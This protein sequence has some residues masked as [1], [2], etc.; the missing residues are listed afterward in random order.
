MSNLPRSTQFRDNINTMSPGPLK[1]G[2]AE[3]Y[4]YTLG[5]C[6]DLLLEK[7]NQARKIN[8][9][10]LGDPSQLPYLAA[11]SVLVQG[12]NE[13]N[14]SF[15]DRVS[16]TFPNAR[17][18]GSRQ[19]I[20]RELQAYATNMQPGVAA[21]LPE[22]AIVGG[23]P[24]SATWDLLYNG[25]K[26]GS[27]PVHV[28]SANGWDWDG[29]IK[30]WRS[31]LVLYM[32]LVARGV[33]GT[34]ATIANGP[35]TTIATGQ[36]VSGVWVPG[37]TSLGTYYPFA[38]VSGLSGMTA[39]NLGDWLVLSSA[40]HGANDGTFQIVQVISATTVLIA[41]SSFVATDTAAWSLSHYPWIAPGLC[42]GAPNQTFGQGAN[43]LPPADLGENINGVW[44]PSADT[45]DYG[46]ASSWGLSC[47][48]QMIQSMRQLVQ[49]W[50]QAGAYYPNI[51]VAF[52][53]GDGTYGNA[54]SPY[55]TAGR[56][57]PNGS[58]G[59]IGENLNG[60]WSPT[61]NTNVSEF[62]AYDC[63]CGGSGDYAHCTVE[64]VT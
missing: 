36:N 15:V 17:N 37:G 13:P 60:V 8:M 26:Q 56:G 29:V 31:W 19:S 59:T 16:L 34:G 42:W 1:T 11:D 48:A 4:M 14:A 3:R 63:F 47:T 28:V 39:E 40:T 52:D 57:L 45:G 18:W 20:L 33:S 27:A 41:N 58:F 25:A 22:M 23:G 43:P 64:N 46:F 44:Q 61:R 6:S 35:A 32:A 24:S 9:P 10:G 50:K 38:Q 7:A 12:P 30:P 49:R 21:V 55:S 51:I 54:Y 2:N 5:L 53:G 62:S